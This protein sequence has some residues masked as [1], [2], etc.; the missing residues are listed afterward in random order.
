MPRKAFS[1]F[2]LATAMWFAPGPPGL[3][4]FAASTASSSFIHIQA[5]GPI[6]M[7]PDP[8]AAASQLVATRV[9]FV[10]SGVV[11]NHMQMPGFSNAFLARDPDGHAIES[12]AQ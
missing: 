11:A 5:V 2:F 4:Q 3:V 6:L 7:T 12:A 8:N 10:S 1:A 9:T